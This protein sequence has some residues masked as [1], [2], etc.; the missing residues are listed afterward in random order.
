MADNEKPNKLTIFQRLDR[1]ISPSSVKVPIEQT[2]RNKYTV[3]ASDIFKTKNQEEFDRQKLQAQQNLMLSSQ[4][5]RVDNEM[6][7]QSLNY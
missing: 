5:K 4:W 1:A 2:N 3:G 7:Q 6:F